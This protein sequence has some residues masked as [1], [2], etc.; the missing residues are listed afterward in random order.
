MNNFSSLF[1]GYL[2]TLRLLQKTLRGLQEIHYNQFNSI[3]KDGYDNEEQ[4][5]DGRG[6]RLLTCTRSV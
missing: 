4:P 2:A 6:S 3:A 5:E 1:R